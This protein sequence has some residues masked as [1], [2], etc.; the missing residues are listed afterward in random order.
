MTAIPATGRARADIM[1]ELAARKSGDR[2]WRRG[3]LAVYFYWLDEELERVQQEAYLA[4]W[5]ENNLGQ[6]A[7]PSL[8]SL[9]E[10][11]IGMALSLLGGGPSAGGTFTSG[12]S[13]SIFLAMMAARNKARAQRGVTRPNIV[14]P[15]TAHLTFD[16]AA[17]ALGLEVRRVPVGPGFRAD[18]PAMAERMDAETVALIGSAPNYPFG[19][20]DPIPD[21]AALARSRGAWMH[22]DACVGGFLAPYVR[23]L[24]HPI[25]P[26]ELDVPGVTSLSADIHKHGM[27]PKGASL[28]L[29]ADAADRE[30][31]KFESRA[32]QRGPYVAYTTQ[33][34]RPGG[35]V[36]AAWAAMMHLGEEGYLRCA[37]L[38]MEAKAI[39]TAGIAAIPG[40]AILEPSDLGIFVWRATDP[41][42]DIGKVAAA[43][44]AE[45]WLVGRQQ[46]PDGI[47]LH[48]NPIHRE[49]AGEYVEAVAR[50]V[51]A[52]RGGAAGRIG[53]NE[54]TY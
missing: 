12:G 3:R 19:T 15:D 54:R 6:R 20:F 31:H 17:E 18:V 44:D 24:G 9:E 1:A 37:R 45:G 5:T 41:A 26:F 8:K 42:L 39:M 53:A 2:D 11:V 28:L 35:A 29:V 21:L 16:R 38:I 22:V 27:A 50:A 46:E 25:P 36:A 7:Y 48:L 14:L 30:W 49:V 43:L 32:W 4:Y 10:E 23:R 33:G 13:E 51:A 47:H 40:L 34:T 52:A